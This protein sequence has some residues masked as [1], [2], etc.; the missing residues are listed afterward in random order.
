MQFIP[1]FLSVV[2][3]VKN[4]SS[5][6]SNILLSAESFLNGFVDDYELIIVDNASDDNSLEVLKGITSE[7]GICNV[8]VY[9]LTKSIDVDSAAW[10]GLENSLGDYAVVVDP[11]VDDIGFIREMLNTSIS[12][13]DVVFAKNSDSDGQGGIFYKA[14]N[15]IYN[16]VYKAANGIKLN[17]EAP[18]FRLLS[19]KVINFVLQHPLP[20]LAY[21]HLPASGGFV[22]KQLTYTYPKSAGN[23]SSNN[24]K[25]KIYQAIDK[26]LMLL[27]STSKAP[28][29][30]ATVLSLFGAFSNLVY[31]A[32]ILGIWLFK[33]EV[34]EGWVSISLQ[35][36]AMFFMI[37]MV[38]FFIGEYLLHNLNVTSNNPTYHL[39]QE[40]TSARMT[41][42]QKLNVEDSENYNRDELNK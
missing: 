21:R 38:L 6:L 18:K 10:V 13:N 39:A 7:S 31:S 28:M 26:G 36:S 34:A 23:F 2:F 14:A 15:Y 20:D 3:V 37:S 12:G 22:K 1:T 33:D 4:Q 30:F 27:V 5:D 40:F 24:E 29:R 25:K 11:R 35:Q 41:R 19:K 42:D 16:W 8:Q 17:D 32:Y 9:A